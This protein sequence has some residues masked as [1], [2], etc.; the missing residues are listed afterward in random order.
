VAVLRGIQTPPGE[1]LDRVDA[2]PHRVPMHAQRACRRTPMPVVLKKSRDCAEK[3]LG[4]VGRVE[5]TEHS[6]GERL[7]GLRANHIE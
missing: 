2:V 5:R 3:F 7:K 4:A 1:P 6:V